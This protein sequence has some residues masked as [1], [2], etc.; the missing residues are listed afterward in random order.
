MS[1]KNTEGLELA[2]AFSAGEFLEEELE[3]IKYELGCPEFVENGV[4][5]KNEDAT[6]KHEWWALPEDI[7]TLNTICAQ[8]KEKK[9][10]AC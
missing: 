8:A 6:H 3:E 1:N 10:K 7:K 4:Y 9:E 5:I 2:F